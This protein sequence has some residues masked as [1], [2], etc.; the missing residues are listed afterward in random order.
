MI[1]SKF[2]WAGAILLAIIPLL[3]MDIPKHY[4]DWEKDV[5]DEII[6]VAQNEYK[7]STEQKATALDG[8]LESNTRLMALMY[9]KAFS[10]ILLLSFSIY[11]FLRSRRQTNMPFWKLSGAVIF[12]L[13]LSVGL[14][15]YSWTSF[16][17]NQSI[18]LLDTS[19]AD[20]SLSNIYNNNFKGKILYVDFWGTTCY[21]CLEE[22]RN[23]TK[24]LKAKYHNR[25]DIA[26][27]YICQGQKLIWK[28]QVQ[29]FDVLGSH[30]FLG[31][32]DY[33]RL[34]R[35]SVKGS[36][37]TMINMPRY[38]ILDKQGKIVENNAYRPSDQDS[39]YTQLDKYLASK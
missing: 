24:P 12:L 25:N 39:I 33:S 23:F 10:G 32:R 9:I 34:F 28:Q 29:R 1:R 13:A 22:F 36:K 31:E 16:S 14:K 19:T 17:G 6:L 26:Y 15:I 5:H 38:L 4:V 21:P 37:D 11:F 18:T 20:T 2:F 27:L 7:Y 3:V 8:I 35:A 30:M